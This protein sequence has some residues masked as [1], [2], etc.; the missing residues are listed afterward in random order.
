VLSHGH[1]DHSGGLEA[2]AKVAPAARLFVHP[3]ADVDASGMTVVASSEP[4]EVVPG[5][6]TTGSVA[7]TAGFEGRS[8]RPDDQ[9]LFFEVPSGV[10]VITGCAHAGV[11]NTAR[12]AMRLAGRNGVFAIIGGMHLGSATDEQIEQ[13]AYSFHRLGVELL[14][15]CHC[16]GRT[17]IDRFAE[18]LPDTVRPCNT[19]SS[20]QLGG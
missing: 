6:F 16:T 10:V 13:T 8:V 1:R 2:V 11:I 19:G 7:E 9:G 18:V 12:Q 14:A 17:A 5:V 3:Q 4:E 15:P 20:F